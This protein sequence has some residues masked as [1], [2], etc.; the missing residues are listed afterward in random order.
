MKP[1]PGLISKGRIEPA[2]A[3][4]RNTERIACGEYPVDRSRKS[5]HIL[6]R[7]HD[8]RPVTLESKI[9]V[10]CGM[11]DILRAFPGVVCL[12]PVRPIV[13]ITPGV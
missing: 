12:R 3:V 6:F 7:K 9:G 5:P 1:A 11:G 4:D 13:S 10:D 8:A 2:R